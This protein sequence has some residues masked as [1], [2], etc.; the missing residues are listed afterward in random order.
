[1]GVEDRGIRV[2]IFPNGQRKEGKVIFVTKDMDSFLIACGK[3]LS[4][5][6]KRIFNHHST[7]IKSVDEINSEDLLSISKGEDFIDTTPK[8]KKG[9]YS[10]LLDDSYYTFAKLYTFRPFSRHF[11]GQ[12][13]YQYFV[14]FL[15]IFDG[16]L[17]K[18]NSHYFIC[19]FS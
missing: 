12:Y 14:L 9:N 4:M 6:A 19:I 16:N 7:E 15:I 8:E 1:M 10:T 13:F 18:N 5:D 2:N 3:R 11:L 17:S